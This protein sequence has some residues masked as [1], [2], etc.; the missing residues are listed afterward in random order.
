[1]ET[2][3]PAQPAE[4][5]KADPPAPGTSGDVDAARN[6][7]AK[8]ARLEGET[9]GRTKLLAELTEQTGFATID[10]LIAA[11]KQNAPDAKAAKAAERAK[12]DAETTR[13][14]ARVAE[15]ESALD[16]QIVRNTIYPIMA[17]L[18]V[19]DPEVAQVA[20]KLRT[21]MDLVRRDGKVVVVDSDGDVVSE[22]PAK[23]LA[24][25]FR[26]EQ[27]AYLVRPT[28]ATAQAKPAAAKN[29]G[30]AK[31]KPAGIADAVAQALR[32]SAAG[33]GSQ[34]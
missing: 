16:T 3:N 1:M 30:A 23:W 15:L 33:G 14:T 32:D 29:G 26:Q 13:L 17:S 27:F 12:A 31:P 24:E 28:T 7:A 34:D 6:A 21:G 11:A 25:Q 22:D 20:L 2:T 5:K 19:R 4:E 18:S 9:R 8:Q 10:E